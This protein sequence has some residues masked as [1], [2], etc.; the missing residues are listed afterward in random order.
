MSLIGFNSAI[1]QAQSLIVLPQFIVNDRSIDIYL[2]RAPELTMPNEDVARRLCIAQRLGGTIQT[3]AG[4]D[5]PNA[6]ACPT[7]LIMQ[8]QKLFTSSIQKRQRLLIAVHPSERITTS[9]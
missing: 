6:R 8:L 2:A 9:H 3:Q 7:H 1:K 5:T 4:A